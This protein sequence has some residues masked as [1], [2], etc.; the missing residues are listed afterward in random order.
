MV[1]MLKH[2]QPTFYNNYPS[3]RC[4][5]SQCTIMNTSVECVCCREIVIILSIQLTEL[6]YVY[7][8]LAQLWVI[9]KD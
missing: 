5:C 1:A 6:G 3:S 9:V 4:E 8:L 7:K 2:D